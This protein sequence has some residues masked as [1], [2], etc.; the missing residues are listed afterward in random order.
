LDLPTAEDGNDH[1]Q[2]SRKEKMPSHIAAKANTRERAGPHQLRD[3]IKIP[4][5][6]F[7]K[8][9]TISSCENSVSIFYILYIISLFY[10]SQ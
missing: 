7:S 10:H 4:P 2:N 1:W 9:S 8:N 3:F 5:F 6:P